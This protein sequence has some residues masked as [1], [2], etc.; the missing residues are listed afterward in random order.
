M[1]ILTAILIVLLSASMTSNA[2]ETDMGS[3]LF[4]DGAGAMALLAD[5]EVRVDGRG[6]ACAKCHGGDAQGRSEG[7]TT[8]P[9][10]NWSSLT[11]PSRSEGPYTV[12]TF[13]HA[14]REGVATN[15]RKLGSAMPRYEVDTQSLESLVRFL[16]SL[17]A[18]ERR[19][20]STSTIAIVFPDKHEQHEF[21][22]IA[23][24]EANA[25]GG[26]WGRLYT[27]TQDENHLINW[28]DVNTR[29][30]PAFDRALE[31]ALTKFLVSASIKSIRLPGSEDHWAQVMTRA[32]I[33]PDVHASTE[34]HKNETGMALQFDVQPKTVVFQ[35]RAP[36]ATNTA[37]DSQH[38]ATDAM[39]SAYVS[40]KV[41]ANAILD[42]GRKVTQ[43][44]VKER[45]DN[46]ELSSWIEVVS[47]RKD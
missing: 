47:S 43:S 40:G 15:G 31:T 30:Q 19:G 2:A 3:R 6:F 9:A 4:L 12:A 22:E 10:I 44:C 7:G 32:G 16:A 26:A 23:I 27:K 39:R 42:C 45:L 14:V 36:Y 46:V 33:S 29:L 28:Q 25:A 41:V 1:R 21:F 5:G 34:L 38:D 13:M 20:I 18:N 37:R 24:S 8:F 17:D 11:D 35:L